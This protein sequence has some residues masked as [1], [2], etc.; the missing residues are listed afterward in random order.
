MNVLFLSPFFPSNAHS[1]CRALQGRGVNVLGV[2]DEPAELH[3]ARLP[4]VNEY[5]FEPRMGDYERLRGVVAELISRHGRIDRLDSN[6]EHWL[7]TEGRLRDEFGVSGL[8]HRET[9]ALRS[10]LSMAS[11][12]ESAD[13]AYPPTIR[14]EPAEGVWEMSRKHGYP[15]VFKPEF[16][17]GAVETF[18]VRDETE[19]HA[20]LRIPRPGHLVQPFV[21]GDI[22]TFDGLTDAS[23]E[24]VFFTS[25]AYDTGILQ[26][27]T[28]G[29]DG[30]YFSI[31]TVPE[32]LERVGRRAVRAFDIKERFFHLEFFACA[33]GS[34]VGLEMNIRPPGGF[35][36]D[37]ISAACN[38]DVYDLWA[39]VITGGTVPDFR[40]ERSYYTAHAGRRDGHRYRLTS[41]E[42][43]RELGPVLFSIQP[44]PDAFA[45]TMGNV[46]YL[47]RSADR[48][49]LARAVALVQDR[50]EERGS[51]R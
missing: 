30:H 23:G 24:I 28:G 21:T 11:V 41:A 25:H 29:L 14:S 7:E 15:L 44:V 26:V 49:T 50:V 19:L 46:A 43:E 6:G 3:P 5:V 13:I 9:T 2:G 33:D 37:M 10:K 1:F 48:D 31:R 34:Y 36:T 18:V 4:H 42:L 35:T 38:F 27:R 17:S 40:Y 47:L 20:A 12:F 16:G 45:V 32:E 22:V 39:A 8:S 51:P